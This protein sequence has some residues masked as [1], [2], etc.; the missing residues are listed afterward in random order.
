MRA[1]MCQQLDWLGLD[2]NPTANAANGPRI[3]REGS[4]VR[5]WVIPTDAERMIT[6]HA[7]ATDI[8]STVCRAWVQKYDCIDR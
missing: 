4:R 7:L 8:G 3:S 2:C 6:T 1:A 5:A